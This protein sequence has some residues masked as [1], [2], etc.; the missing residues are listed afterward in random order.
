MDDIKKFL[1][2]VN[3]GGSGGAG[4]G[5]ISNEL[6]LSLGAQSRDP[7]VKGASAVGEIAGEVASQ[8]REAAENARK[9]RLQELQDMMDPGKYERRRDDRGGFTFFD[10]TGKQIDV[11]TYAGRTGLTR[12]DALKGSENPIDIQFLNDYGNMNNLM[13]KAFNGED[14]SEDLKNNGMDTK[15]KPQD[16]GRELIKRYP[17]IFGVGRYEDSLRN[18]NKPVFKRLAQ[19]DSMFEGYQ[20]PF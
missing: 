2:S 11:N 10:P 13:G 5:G 1:S 6:N 7:L 17:H 19:E 14:I 15:A 16:F 8:E 20:D 12:A 18:M 9:Q 4:I 3:I